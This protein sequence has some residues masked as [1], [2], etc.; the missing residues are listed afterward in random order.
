MNPFR[1]IAVA[2]LVLAISTG[3]A[4]VAY[5]AG[6]SHELT[7]G[8]PAYTTIPPNAQVV[9]VHPWGFGF[10]FFFPFLFF[11]LFFAVLRGLFWRGHY[12][13]GYHCMRH[14]HPADPNTG[15]AV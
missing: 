6:A 5:N 11:F 8:R 10:G 3:I 14:E 9:Y 15:T 7:G 12:H 4:V 1:T 13:R 2:L